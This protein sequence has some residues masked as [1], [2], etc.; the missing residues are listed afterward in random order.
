MR[1]VL[2]GPLQFLPMAPNA[3]EDASHGRK[4]YR[5]S[6]TLA[7]PLEEPESE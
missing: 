6:W 5:A 2:Y 7:E 1:G 4:D 3:Q